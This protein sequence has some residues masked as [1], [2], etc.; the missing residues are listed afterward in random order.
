MES[1]PILIIKVKYKEDIK[2]FHLLVDN[3]YRKELKQNYILFV[4]WDS[5]IENKVEFEALKVKDA[6]YDKVEDLMKRLESISIK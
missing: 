4:N 1:K 3:E 5:S 2:N 6:P